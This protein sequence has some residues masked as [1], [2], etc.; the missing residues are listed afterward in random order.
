MRRKRTMY[1]RMSALFLA[2]TLAL[3]GVA[4][5]QERFGVLQGR[6]TDQQ[7][8]ALP[9]VTVS[10]HNVQSGEERAFVTDSN[11]QYVAPD[12]NP[13]RYTVTFEL[14]GFGKVERPDISVALGRTFS[15]DT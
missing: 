2:V 10:V 13:G 11:G 12:L 8:A 3:T 4:S 7:G 14:S 1:A 6:V 15:V 5:A 9:C